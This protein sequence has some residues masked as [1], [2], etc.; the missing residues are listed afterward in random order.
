MCMLS[1]IVW[2]HFLIDYSLSTENFSEDLFEVVSCYFPIDYTPPATDPYAVKK[3]DLVLMLRSSLA[4]YPGFAPYCLPLLLD[5]LSSDMQS[6]KIDSLLTLAECAEPYGAESLKPFLPSIWQAVK[7]E[8][9]RYM[10]NALGVLVTFL[11]DRLKDHHSVIPHVLRGLLASSGCKNLLEED[12]ASLL[13]GIF[14]EVQ[15]QAHMQ[16]DRRAVFSTI[17]TLLDHRLT[18]VLP[19][20]ADFVF[21]FIQVLD[22]EKDPRNL[23]IGF[24]LVCIICAHFPIVLVFSVFQSNKSILDDVLHHILEDCRHHL[25]EPELKLFAPTACLLQEVASS[26]DPACCNVLS[27][28][29]PMLISQFQAHPQNS[30]RKA[31]L[32]TLIGFLKI[33]NVFCQAENNASSPLHR[34]SDQISTLFLS[35]LSDSAEE[36]RSVGIH[37]IRV[38]TQQPKLLDKNRQ[39]MA[40][41]HLVRAALTDGSCQIRKESAETLA[42]MSL[43]HPEVIHNEVFPV[44]LDKLKD[45]S[46]DG[47]TPHEDVLLVLAGV[48]RHADTGRDAIAHIISYIRDPAACST[49][50]RLAAA[51]EALL[52]IVTEWA[53]SGQSLE[54]AGKELVV[55][56]AALARA[57]RLRVPEGHVKVVCDL[58]RLICSMVTLSLDVGLGEAGRTAQKLTLYTLVWMFL[59]Q[60]RGS[61]SE[62]G[63]VR[64]FSVYPAVNGIQ[65]RTRY[66]SRRVSAYLE[67]RLAGGGDD[68]AGRTKAF[69]L[70]VWI[71]KALVVR[72]H[73]RANTFKSKSCAKRRD[74]PLSRMH[75]NVRLMYRQRFF[76]ETSPLLVAAFHLAPK[77]MKPHYL[78]ALSI[79]LRYIPHQVML[80]E[81]PPLLPLLLESLVCGD[82]DLQLSTLAALSALLTD[83]PQLLIGHADTIVP[84]LLTLTRREDSMKLRISALDCL[85]IVSS[86]P[87]QVVFPHQQQVIRQLSA[88]LDDK[89]R[90]VRQAAAKTR[91]EWCILGSMVKN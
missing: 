49:H 42:Q 75:C 35:L 56:L 13:R 53:S 55:Q 4:A 1:S 69:N 5:K 63:S 16:A 89:K 74:G 44:L 6:A 90:L 25:A 47:S 3:D 21:G 27:E 66:S 9:C 87:H 68:D 72:A 46:I 14:K 59:L 82:A 26:S 2:F 8:V 80:S 73:P 78:V 65:S 19:L 43:T 29:V 50:T 70:W 24:R 23:Y 57:G 17:A 86:L 37:G 7:K 85:R 60:A 28:V 39:T 77:D 31:L 61:H 15:V 11:V 36:M 62:Q 10:L 18:D 41:D 40:A 83:T 84:L 79:M 22:G 45:G 20:G 52:S 34:D 33:A 48:S 54:S 51:L 32:E 88:A 64:A 58:L 12:I 81:F 38:L 91:G 76:L 71:S 30:H 67:T